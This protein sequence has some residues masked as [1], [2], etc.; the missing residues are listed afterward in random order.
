M[1]DW[2]DIAAGSRDQ[3]TP[4][5]EATAN[6]L[7]NNTLY[8]QERALRCG[9][10]A[11]GVRLA[12]ARGIVSLSQAAAGE[13]HLFTTTV[14]FSS[15]ADDGDPG[16]SVAPTIKLLVTEYIYTNWSASVYPKAY[17]IQAGTRTASA[18]S[19]DIQFENPAATDVGVRVHWE[20]RAAVTVGE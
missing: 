10:H 17:Y 13:D 3:D 20:A 5:W 12:E 7:Y 9:T 6:A 16:F 19:L 18:F 15:A 2:T 14:T 11:T 4:V 1:A 8:N